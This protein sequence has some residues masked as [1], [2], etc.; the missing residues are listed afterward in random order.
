MGEDKLGELSDLKEIAIGKIKAAYNRSI[1]AEATH[2]VLWDITENKRNKVLK[3]GLI[4]SFIIIIFAYLP[5][6]FG[7]GLLNLIFSLI[8]EISAFLIAGIIF[9]G[10]FLTSYSKIHKQLLRS[11]ILLRRQSLDFLQYKLENLDKEEFIEELK[12]LEVN[13]TNLKEK[14]QVYINKMSTQLLTEK[15]YYI[16]ELE[17]AGFKKHNITQQ[18]I[19]SANEKLQKFTA[20]RTCEAWIKFE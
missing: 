6:L 8:A 3:I 14:T 15:T 9:Y 10:L 5:F 18:A 7:Y 19:D 17:K 16:E 12:S 2:S 4:I 20:L 13:D 1:D 11:A